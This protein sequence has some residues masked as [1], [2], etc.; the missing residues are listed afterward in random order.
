MS[1]DWEKL[2]SQCEIPIHKIWIHQFFVLFL[3]K[4]L[5][6]CFQ[7]C[8]GKPE[9]CTADKNQGYYNKHLQKWWSFWV[10][11]KQLQ[12]LR[13]LF[14]V[15]YF[16]PVEFFM[17]FFP[18]TYSLFTSTFPEPSCPV[19]YILNGQLNATEPVRYGDRVQ[20]TCHDGYELKGEGHFQCSDSG[21]YNRTPGTCQGK[22]LLSVCEITQTCWISLLLQSLEGWVKFWSL[23]VCLIILR[24]Q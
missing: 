11:N 2:P 16:I 8:A 4:Q 13:Q 23:S 15:C 20:I 5:L 6:L 14:I 10:E 21:E 24:N 1:L 22:N 17:F 18:F 19:L 9:E 12:K 3:C 7:A